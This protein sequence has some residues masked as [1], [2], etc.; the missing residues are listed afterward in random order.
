MLQQPL[1]P[2][3]L[4]HSPYK[5]KFAIPRQANLVTSV[6]STLEF[7]APFDSA[8]FLDGA[9]QFSHFW[10]I[11]GFHQNQDAGWKTKVRPP[12]LGGNQKLGVFATRSSFR[13][14]GLGLSL[15]E[16]SR[17]NDKE[18][19]SSI[20]FIGGD[21][22]DGTPIYDIKPYIEYADHPKN[23]H[24]GFAQDPPTT[25]LNVQWSSEARNQAQALHL[26]EHHFQVVDEVLSQDPRPAYHRKQITVREYGIHLFNF[27]IRWQVQ[28]D[29][30]KS[31]CLIVGIHPHA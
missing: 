30:A 29:E 27:N 15:F 5:E 12:R 3:G 22:V 7:N 4:I 8:E 1:E 6:R 16:V 25:R 13:P 2:I 11:F 9:Q 24:S 14:N 23:S 28:A 20:E 18:T 17:I 26:Q 21:L 31:V 19:G 10:L